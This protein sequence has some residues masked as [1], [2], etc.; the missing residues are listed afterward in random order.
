MW[1]A[2]SLAQF[3]W[4][5]LI[6]VWLGA[7]L[8]GFASGAAGFALGIVASAIWL[9]VLDPVHVTMLIV[10]GGTL[11]QL[12]TIWPQR[13][14]L[15]PKRLWPFCV[16]GLAGIPIGVALLV[17]TDTRA[18]KAALGVFL[19]AYGVFAL[20]A[21]PLPHVK[22]GRLADAAVGFAGGILGGLGGLSGVLP[23]I[24][25]Q[26]RGW[27]KDVARAVYQ[28]F[29]VMAHLTTLLL[30]GAVAMD[31]RGLILLLLAL[32][33]LL[34]GAIIGWRV[35]GRL[36]EQRFR[37]GLAALLVVSGLILVF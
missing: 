28:P 35:Y 23:A 13:R 12:G 14:A 29:I 37:Q 19:A 17:H 36:D 27:P 26:V 6:L 2:D 15:D 11:I 20:L 30:I 5:T 24:W 9:H 33:A 10:C 31:R 7:F 1:L 25:T 16:A 21:P 18:L 22:A 8:G 3:S 32:P 4:A 34:I